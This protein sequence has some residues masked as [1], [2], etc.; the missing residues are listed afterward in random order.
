M[1][2]E[3]R[4][5]IIAELIGGKNGGLLLAVGTLALH[6][7][8]VSLVGGAEEISVAFTRNVEPVMTGGTPAVPA[9]VREGPVKYNRGKDAS[10]GL[11]LP[12]CQGRRKCGYQGI[13]LFLREWG[14][15]RVFHGI[16][17]L[18]FENFGKSLEKA[19]VI[20]VNYTMTEVVGGLYTGFSRCALP[21][22]PRARRSSF[23]R[24]R[25]SSA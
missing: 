11:R 22:W 4:L 25:G 17:L 9:S 20:V 19:D 12:F 23:R 2:L 24:N 14:A 7:F 5:E 15:G 21:D 3:K 18:F 8:A 10:R 6:P 1:F 13:F 16:P